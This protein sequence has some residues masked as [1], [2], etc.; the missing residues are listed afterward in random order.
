[1]SRVIFEDER[2][3]LQFD[4]GRADVACV[5]GLV[6]YLGPA[7]PADVA[8]WMRAR[9]TANWPQGLPLNPFVLQTVVLDTPIPANVQA[10]ADQATTSIPPALQDWLKARG[11]LEGR[12][13]RDL[14]QLADV[15]IPVES[16]A[17]FTALFDPGG[18][19]ASW[20]TD[21]V[22]AALRSFFAQGGKRCYLVRMGDPVAPTD[23]QPV[24]A[25][26]N[27]TKKQAKLQSLLLD[28][29]HDASDPR[30]WHGVGHLAGLTDVSFLALPDL[31]VLAAS[32]PAPAAGQVP[33]VP[34][35]PEQ[36]VECSQRD[37]TPQ[38]SRVYA[39]PAPRLTLADYQTW[40]ESVGGILQYLSSN[41]DGQSPHLREIQ[42]VAG[43]P[44]PLDFDAA[45]AV[46]NPSSAALAQ[47]IHDVIAEHLPEP[48]DQSEN[49]SAGKLSSAFLQLA[50]PW[51]KTTGSHV[52]LES[53]EPPDGALVGMLA[54]NALT[55]GTF[56]SATRIVPAEVFDVWPALPA[57]DTTSALP[58]LIWDGS[59]KPLIERLSLF[60][61]TPGGLQ[62]LSDV[63]TYSGESYRPARTNRLVSVICRAARHLGENVIF[64]S[65]GPELW[66]QI[67]TLLQQLMTRL[68]NLKALDGASTQEAFSVRCDR[69]TMTQNDLD[70]GR[71]VAVLTFT[72]AGTVELIRVTLALQTSGASLQDI[73]AMQLEVG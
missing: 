69:S 43:L 48:E 63:T 40:A 31:A 34:G 11:W 27:R 29:S 54:R 56:N 38:Q 50:Y 57:P 71:L 47:D 68:W 6:R 44:L 60:G 5:V 26:D 35:G 41:G 45:T 53:L 39:S 20:G 73:Q 72:A 8:A 22:A 24:S 13:A 52:L 18:S 62:L 64:E 36:F 55:R 66:G 49:F 67:Q 59:P 25:Q 32:Q 21:Y 58:P 10:W 42:L 2:P 15:P 70:N 4:P 12:Y 1:M 23:D 17:G 14:D 19:S 3:A 7:I 65:N 46:E 16:Y 9:A 51:L 28:D 37:V 61:F 30:T 33:V